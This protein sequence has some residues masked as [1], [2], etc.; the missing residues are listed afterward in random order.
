MSVSRESIESL[1]VF[2][3]LS[4]DQLDLVA[5]ILGEEEFEAGATVYEEGDP[6][7]DFYVVAEG[8][9][10]L[11]V[12][13]AEVES[14]FFTARPG[15][16]FGHLSLLDGGVRPACARAQEP[17]RLI[18][19]EHAA[20]FRFLEEHPEPGSL[21]L[22][23]LAIAI[24]ERT[25]VLAYK[26]RAKVEWSLQVAG[27]LDHSLQRLITDR[28]EVTMDLVNGRQVVGSLLKVEKTDAASDIYLRTE[29]GKTLIIP[30]HAMA[31][32]SFDADALPPA[33][34]EMPEF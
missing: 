5:G 16:A 10:E 29:D 23:D 31:L 17:T 33:P 26:Y 12:R 19:M 20:F 13:V 21:L 2:E 11:F 27:S 8:A 1:S 32:A 24:A 30:Y 18:K 7:T 25:R 28:V 14:T 9:V 34:S 3:S 22:R 4:P 6:G 15:G